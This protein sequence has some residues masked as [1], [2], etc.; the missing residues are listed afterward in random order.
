MPATV[1]AHRRAMARMAEPL[2]EIALFVVA[3]LV[4]FGVRAIT[5]GAPAVAQHHATQVIDFERRLGIAWERSVQDSVL[6][7]TVLLDAANAV[8]VY[9]HWPVIIV[10]GVLLYRHRRRRYYQLRTAFI[11]SGLIGLVIFALYPVAPP[12]LTDLPLVDTVTQ[13]AEGYRQVVPKA[14]VNQYA[15]LPS[16]HAGWNVLL[17]IIV[18]RATSNRLLRGLAVVGP[19]AMVLAVVAT[20]NHFIVD[21]LAGVAIALGVLFV[22]HVFE[23]RT[24]V[25]RHDLAVHVLRRRPPRRERPGPPPRRREPATPARRG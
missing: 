25:R 13:R 20:A 22:V 14:L 12:R 1:I 7:N 11:I 19:A 23:G 24:L 3:Y 9:G 10:A 5:E 18:V 17:G 21:V 8:Y 2:R 4:Y 16:F 15:A 6:H